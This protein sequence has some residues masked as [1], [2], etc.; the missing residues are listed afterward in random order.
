MDGTMTGKPLPATRWASVAIPTL[1]LH[2]SA[3]PTWMGN[4]AQALVSLLP[5][6]KSQTLEG[7]AHNVAAD[8]LVPALLQ[9]FTADLE[10][11]DRISN[12]SITWFEI[13]VPDAT[14]AQQFY[15]AVFPWTFEAMEGSGGGY[16]VVEVG[17]QDIG[18]L[19]AIEASAPA[20]RQCRLYFQVDDLEDTLAHVLQ[21]GGTVQ[22][23]RMEVPGARWIGAAQDP[24]GQPIGFVTGN[25]AR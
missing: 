9:F 22:Q 4:A 12:S 13:D 14:R 16:I 8:A 25:T 17:G 1:V 6:A 11:K 24:F 10:E 3:S 23:E 5:M 18:A 15:G 2:G 20:G 21:A 19:L 7:Q